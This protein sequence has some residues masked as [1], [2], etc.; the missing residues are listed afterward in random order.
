MSGQLAKLNKAVASLPETLKPPPPPPLPPPPPKPTAAAK[1]PERFPSDFDDDMVNIITAVRPY[2]MT[3]PDKLHALVTATRYVVRYG[4]PGAIVECGVWRGG[5]M[6]AVARCLDA[7]GVH[8]RDLYLYDTFEGM[9]G[10]TDLDRRHDGASAAGLLETQDR[11]SMVWARATLEDVQQGFSRLPYPKERVHFVKGPVEETV[12]QT[13][14]DEIAILRLD[15]DWYE[16]TAHELT[17]MYDRL[18]SGGVLLLDDYGYWQGARRA[19]DEFL[20]RTG[21]RLLLARMGSGR[22]AV[23]P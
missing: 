13:L 14:P 10:P 8:D 22:F 9:T 21:E 12:P 23:K 20:E 5:S 16:S 4:I 3:S 17:H 11:D 6:Q 19:T 18:V 7:A 2:S 1:A 15:T